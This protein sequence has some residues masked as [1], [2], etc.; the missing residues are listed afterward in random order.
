MAVNH[1]DG[2]LFL[3]VLLYS[4]A[5]V[6]RAVS[7]GAGWLAFFFIPLG[8]VVGGTVAY[9]D[10]KLICGILGLAL[11]PAA[12]VSQGWLKQLAALPVMILY[13]LLPCAF[14]WAGLLDTWYGS[15]WLVQHPIFGALF[16]VAGF[17]LAIYPSQ[18][19]Y[20]RGNPKA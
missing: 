5:A 4:V 18:T 2:T 16:G 3:S 1:A 15:L 13:I 12:K 11:P 8:L 19:R 6:V 10:R 9:T 7:A 14:V 17:I 20:F